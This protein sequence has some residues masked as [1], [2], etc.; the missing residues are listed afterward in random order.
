MPFKRTLIAL[1]CIIIFKSV[2]YPKLV[3]ADDM[4]NFGDV[5]MIQPLSS[6]SVQPTQPAQT[7]SLNTVNPQNQSTNPGSITPEQALNPTPT[8]GINNS[9]IN[10][11]GIYPIGGQ[12]LIDRSVNVN[13]VVASSITVSSI[14]VTNS[15]STTAITTTT[16]KGNLTFNPTSSGIVGTTTNDN[17]QA[18]NVGEAVRA[19]RVVG[20]A[21][22]LSNGVWVNVAS[23]ALTAG[24]W[25][26][27]A[28]GGIGV[29]SNGTI[30]QIGI[31][32]SVN[33][34]N[35]TTDQVDGDNQEVALGPFPNTQINTYGAIPSYRL[36]ISGNTT[37]YLKA[38]ANFSSGSWAAWGRISARR[39][40]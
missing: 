37:V 30:T 15:F 27:S 24:D 29:N 36:S 19:N 7:N 3:Y 6:Q 38:L 13:T 34:G 12:L 9:A 26:V 5:G 14:N 4:G 35:T 11:A 32:V 31:A 28:I 21:I 22:S 25:D 1:F 16:I 39:I 2:Y 8:S 23:I 40:R 20:S 17:T 10:N 18:G 33:S